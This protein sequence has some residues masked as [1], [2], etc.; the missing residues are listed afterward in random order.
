MVPL[1]PSNFPEMR[2]STL[3]AIDQLTDEQLVCEI[4]KGAGSTFGAKAQP[5]LAAALAQRQA[6]VR[7][8]EIEKEIEIAEESNRIASDALDEA[9]KANDKSSWAIGISLI[10][11]AE[12]I[13]IAIVKS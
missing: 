6:D 8:S 2:K 5:V 12:T 3:A 7:K 13:I 1:D 10:A 4:E 11:I 9:K